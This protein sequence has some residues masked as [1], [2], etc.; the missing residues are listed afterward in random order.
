MTTAQFLDSLRNLLD[1]DALREAEALAMELPEPHQLA[2]ELV[3][4]QRL[5]QGQADAMLDDPVADQIVAGEPA[6][7]L[8]RTTSAPPAARKAPPRGVS[9]VPI[10]VGIFAL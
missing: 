7:R 3:R 6:P 1:S 10:I 9:A 2:A 4:R 5:T 8:A